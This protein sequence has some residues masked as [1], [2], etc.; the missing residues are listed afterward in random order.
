MTER[1]SELEAALLGMKHRVMADGKP[2]WCLLWPDEEVEAEKFLSGPPGSKATNENPIEG[3]GDH[4][5]MARAALEVLEES[6]LIPNRGGC[7]IGP[8][9]TL[10]PGE[11]WVVDSDCM[12]LAHGYLADWQHYPPGFVFLNDTDQTRSWLIEYPVVV[13]TGL[14]SS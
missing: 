11:S 3:H 13:D 9:I 8:A 4:C 10:A 5:L 12:I 1:E 6:V 7:D 14:R 2:C